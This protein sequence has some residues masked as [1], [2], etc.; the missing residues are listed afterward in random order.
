MQDYPFGSQSTVCWLENRIG[1]GERLLCELP[2]DSGW[3]PLVRRRL[4]ELQS[5][6]ETL[7]PAMT[8]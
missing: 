5:W 4:C 2:D 6:L 3:G 7:R 8:A 1:E